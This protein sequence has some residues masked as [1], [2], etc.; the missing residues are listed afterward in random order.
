M[1][2]YEQTVSTPFTG[3]TDVLGGSVVSGLSRLAGDSLGTGGAGCLE[4]PFPA[5]GAG[6]VPLWI[7]LC[8]SIHTPQFLRAAKEAQLQQT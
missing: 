6:Y 3:F 2:D 7:G 5:V 1:R 4:G 8:L